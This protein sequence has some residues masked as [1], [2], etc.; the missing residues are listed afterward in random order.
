MATKSWRTE[1]WV[2]VYI[3][4]FILAVILAAFSYKWFDLG[5]LRPSFRWTT[6]SQLASSA[7]SWRAAAMNF[8]TAV[9]DINSS[10][11]SVEDSKLL[12]IRS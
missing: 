2:A 1:D 4:F 8:A 3:G 11:N 7:Q 9:F 5:S 10:N 12:L 6:D